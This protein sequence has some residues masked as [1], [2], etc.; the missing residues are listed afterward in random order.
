MGALATHLL[1]EP[2]SIDR[3]SQDS[4]AVAAV[5]HVCLDRGA[6]NGPARRADRP[7]ATPIRGCGSSA[8]QM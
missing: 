3:S 6:T 1:V 5:F 8:D 7:V 4:Q 2:R